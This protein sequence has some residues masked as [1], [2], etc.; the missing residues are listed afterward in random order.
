ME[1]DEDQELQVK[2]DLATLTRTLTSENVN[3]AAIFTK[4]RGIR[5]C[6][7]ALEPEQENGTV[8]ER[9]KRVQV[10]E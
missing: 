4:K 6:T 10:P 1:T 2:K 8:S 5:S 7:P 9:L 3:P